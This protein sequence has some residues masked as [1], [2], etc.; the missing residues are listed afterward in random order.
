VCIHGVMKYE[1]GSW[2]AVATRS[3]V[4]GNGSRIWCA[5]GITACRAGT[6]SSLITCCV[7]SDNPDRI[8]VPYLYYKSLP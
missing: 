7:G 5:K 6:T 1:D 3:A 2:P 4:V 8:V